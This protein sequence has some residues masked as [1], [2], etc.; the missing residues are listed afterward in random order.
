MIERYFIEIEGV[1]SRF[2][3]VSTYS[4]HKRVINDSFGVI[5]GSL[6]FSNGILDFLEVIRI[7]DSG[8]PLKKK[9]KY[10]F[11]DLENVLIFRYDNV[12]HHPDITS[13]PLHKH[14]ANKVISCSE[15]DLFEVLSEIQ[16]L[17][18][19]TD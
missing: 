19:G 16:S 8:E 5:G 17:P 7:S 18:A 11:R 6:Y 15:P 10:H 13:F 4:L 3:I 1:I 2:D 9:F 14:I 12:P